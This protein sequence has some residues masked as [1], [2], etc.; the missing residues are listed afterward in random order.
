MNQ[1]Q[2]NVLDALICSRIGISDE[3]ELIIMAA[4]AWSIAQTGSLTVSAQLTALAL[5]VWG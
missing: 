3:K 5:Q 1:G 4:L 2:F